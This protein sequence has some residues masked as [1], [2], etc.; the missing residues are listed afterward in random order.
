MNVQVDG[1][2]EEAFHDIA[3][4]ATSNVWRP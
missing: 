2:V 4:A 3:H 1:A